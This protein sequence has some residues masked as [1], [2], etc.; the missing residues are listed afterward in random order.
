MSEYYAKITWEKSDDE[1]YVDNKYSRAH[2]WTF[3]GGLCVPAS[4]SPHIVPTP[5]SLESH[6]DPEEA[7]VASISSCH[8]LFFLAFLAKRKYVVERYIDEASGLMEEDE[9]GKM[10]MTRVILR[11]S[12]IF[13]GERI[14]SL[15]LIETLHH[16]SHEQCFIANSVKTNIIVEIPDSLVSRV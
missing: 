2:T 10:S 1:A 6:V 11:P 4:S 3:D 9:L 5:Y 7:F 12:V 15:E 14:P 16:Q 13:S 8:M